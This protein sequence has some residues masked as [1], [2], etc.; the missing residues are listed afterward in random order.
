MSL[1][2]V[3]VKAR[4]PPEREKCYNL[5]QCEARCIIWP[6]LEQNSDSG[7][8]QG[9]TTNDVSEHDS[10]KPSHVMWWEKRASRPEEGM[11][12]TQLSI[13]QMLTSIVQTLQ[14]SRVH[15]VTMDV[16]DFSPDTPTLNQIR[17]YLHDMAKNAKETRNK[18]AWS[19]SDAT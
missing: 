11:I 5:K 9:S 12:I 14:T 10:K 15:A 8:N 6:G 18:L 13:F 7:G 19:Q 2:A 4:A 1:L 17:T 3:G 16:K